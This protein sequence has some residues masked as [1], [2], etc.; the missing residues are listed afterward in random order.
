MRARLALAMPVLVARESGRIVGA[1]MGY[2][3]ASHEWPADI[4]EEWA[5]FEQ[6][7]PGLSGRMAAYD[8]IVAQS[9]P[10]TPHYYLG[11]LGV[12]PSAHGRGFGK[13]L[14]EAFCE[15]SANDPLSAGVFLET[16]NESNLGFYGRAGF[17]ETGRDTMGSTMVWCMY[18][19]HK[20]K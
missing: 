9:M 17:V 8:G 1:A 10:S 3:T 12:E 19:Q 4:T 15:L 20:K 11:A 7:I 5:R 18:L 13:Q 14:L 2:S 16:G 6:A